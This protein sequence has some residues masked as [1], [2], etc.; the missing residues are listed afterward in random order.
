MIQVHER[1][2]LLLC[3]PS[4]AALPQA[5]AFN[6]DLSIWDVSQVATMHSAFDLTR[7]VTDPASACNQAAIHE[8]WGIVQNNTAFMGK[9]ASWPRQA[10]VQHKCCRVWEIMGADGICEPAL[11]LDADRCMF[12]RLAQ[13]LEAAEGAKDAA[14]DQWLR[15]WSNRTTPEVA[16]HFSVRDGACT[17]LPNLSRVMTRALTAIGNA[18]IPLGRGLGNL[19]DDEVVSNNVAIG[20]VGVKVD[21]EAGS[22]D[23]FRFTYMHGGS[24]LCAH[25]IKLISPSPTG[26]IALGLLFQSKVL[27]LAAVRSSNHT[28][29]ARAGGEPQCHGM[30]VIPSGTAI[31]ATLLKP[32][33]A[34]TGK[35]KDEPLFS[36]SLFNPPG[37][38]VV[39]PPTIHCPRDA[40]LIS[41][42]LMTPTSAVLLNKTH[43][44]RLLVPANT[45][46]D[47]ATGS[48]ARANVLLVRATDE[49]N[50][51]SIIVSAP[52]VR[53]NNAQYQLPAD[54]RGNVTFTATNLLGLTASCTTEL[55]T[56]T[57]QTIVAGRE[58]CDRRPGREPSR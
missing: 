20:G 43:E 37:A 24:G 8:S 33:V 38:G 22:D 28:A 51:H 35:L 17:F 6:Q 11:W 27:S 47:A 19:A 55:A 29:R 31:V 30:D 53:L 46:T 34:L 32:V 5:F 23:L 42:F 10:S 45:A 21:F 36:V 25:P 4:D 39:R 3:L 1:D 18:F 57:T 41:P 49:Y 44:L 48:T 13:E 40:A 52:A 26:P 58:R 9:M 56:F 7:L 54:F 50:I 15:V 12:L 16:E 14:R 2:A